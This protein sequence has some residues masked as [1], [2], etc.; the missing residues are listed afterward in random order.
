MSTPYDPPAAAPRRGFRPPRMKHLH[1]DLDQLHKSLLDL[2]GSVEIAIRDA[3]AALFSR[4]VELAHKVMERERE[5]DLAEV[6]IEEDCL[7]MLALHQPVAT[8][9]RFVIAALKVDNDLERMGD[10][11]ESIAARALQLAELP[12]VEI[13]E[14]LFAM[15]Q[16]AKGMT[17]KALECLVHADVVLARQI[18]VDD[19]S[20]D[21]AQRSMFDALQERMRQRPEQIE[22]CVLLLSATRQVERVADLATNIAEDVIFLHQGEIVRHKR[23]NLRIV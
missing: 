18:L 23:A 12:P 9:L 2:G 16:A 1:R 15:V 14:P 6:Q 21:S 3:T 13:P 7:K 20:V 4:D 17:R 19:D 22:A 11:A 10:A 5:I 8:D